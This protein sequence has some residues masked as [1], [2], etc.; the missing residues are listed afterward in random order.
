M[1]KIAIYGGT[2]AI[3][4]ALTQGLDNSS[5]PVEKIVLIGRNENI[6]E[7][8]T[9]D[10]EDAEIITQS[11]TVISH[12]HLDDPEAVE[13]ADIVVVTAGQVRTE[14]MERE[15]LLSRNALIIKGIG[16][17]IRKKAPD[18]FIIV[19]TNP[20]DNMTAVMH[21]VVDGRPGKICGMAA[22][23]DSARFTKAIAQEF[24]VEAAAVTNAMVFGEHGPHMVPIFSQVR[25]K[26]EPI[27]VTEEQR[28]RIR[29]KVQNA[30]HTIIKLLK[31]GGATQGPAAGII[32]IIGNYIHPKGHPV[33]SAAMF[34]GEYGGIA[35]IFMGAATYIDRSGVKIINIPISES[36]ERALH[37][38]AA[39][40]K[41]TNADLGL[42]Y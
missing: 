16:E 8:K 36:E 10:F 40:I 13:G 27:T 7:G 29:E 14:K 37:A 2:G 30:G 22:Q 5:L 26:G 24:K 42:V 32:S 3:A 35:G 9:I 25:I 18:A 20:L 31:T 33:P 19:V 38:S 15:D 23:L 1:A 11:S 12:A 39:A 41:K 28:E 6:A 21:N 34:R 4:S 17:A